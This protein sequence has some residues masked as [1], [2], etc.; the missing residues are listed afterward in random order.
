MSASLLKAEKKTNPIAQHES[1]AE[2]VHSHVCSSSEHKKMHSRFSCDNI[3]YLV[4][5][6]YGISSAFEQHIAEWKLLSSFMSL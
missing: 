2:A 4:S 5:L 1:K 3:S 6:I